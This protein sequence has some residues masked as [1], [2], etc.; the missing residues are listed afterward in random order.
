MP[1]LEPTFAVVVLLLLAALLYSCWKAFTTFDYGAIGH[2]FRALVAFM[3][4]LGILVGRHVWAAHA[5][6]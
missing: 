2:A 5:T 4:L 6:L 1:T 3:L